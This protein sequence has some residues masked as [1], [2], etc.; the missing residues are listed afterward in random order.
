MKVTEKCDV[1]SF[2]VLALEVIKGVH[3]GDDITSLTSP[4][5]EKIEL[6]DLLDHRLPDP[7]PEIKEV[8]RSILILT[9]SCVNSNPGLRPTMH[10]V[11]QKIE[12][13]LQSIF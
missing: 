8:L 3:P 5:T 1:Y 11:S 13:C 12:A 4:L 6:K 2:G 9:I 10:D 7:L